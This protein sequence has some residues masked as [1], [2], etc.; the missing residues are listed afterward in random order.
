[1]YKCCIFDL[2]G[3]VINTIYALN[4]TINLMLG[5]LGYGPIDEGHTKVFVADGYKKFVE[6]ALAYSGDEGLADLEKALAIYRRVFSENCLYRIEAYDGMKELLEYLKGRGIKI[7]VLTNKAHAQAVDNIEAVYGKGYFDLITGE[8]EGLKRKPDPAGAFCT[9]KALGA[10]PEECLYFGDT[11]T[12]MKTGIAAGM[13][14]VGVTWGF[15]GREELE[16]FHPRYIVDDPREVI[17]ILEGILRQDAGTSKD[18]FLI[19]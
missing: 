4:R 1:M 17:G 6:R 13:D 18:T 8:Q 3:T 15:R 11:N 2:D 9:A 12:D 14:T 10:R 5:E 7:A 16:A 19:S